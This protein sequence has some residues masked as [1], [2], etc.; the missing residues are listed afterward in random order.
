MAEASVKSSRTGAPRSRDYTVPSVAAAVRILQWLADR[1]ATLSQI[2]DA[3]SLS[4]STTFALLKTLQ[5]S[6]V[7]GYDG[8]TRQYFLGV[9]LLGLGEAAARQVDH[10]T[11]V[12][13]FLRAVVAATSLTGI[14]AQ[15]IHGGLVVVH[16]EEGSSAIRATMRIGQSVPIGVGAMGKVHAAFAAPPRRFGAT[17]RQRLEEIRRLGYAVSHEEYRL[18][19]RAVAAPIFDR[20]GEVALVLC[21]IG[22]AASI[23]PEAMA[24]YGEVLK[25]C[26]AEASQAL[27]MA[28]EPVQLRVRRI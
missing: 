3:L 19:V 28:A 16:Q 10:V 25:T 17:E 8:G 4:K 22:F 1:R 7:L 11:T 5:Q 13:P 24:G 12:K 14:L 26:C 6:G 9:A 18:G 2:S 23:P 20:Q 27:G 21:L 15:R